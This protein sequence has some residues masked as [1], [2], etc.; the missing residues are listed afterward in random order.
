MVLLGTVHWKVL[1]GTKNGSSKA[2]LQKHP[3]G[4][5]I[6]KSTILS[7]KQGSIKLIKS[8]TLNVVQLNVVLFECLNPENNIMVFPKILSSMAVFNIDNNSK[9]FLNSKSAY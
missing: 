8:D 3:F 2:S 7:F 5:F 9:C 6:F 1:L 4:A